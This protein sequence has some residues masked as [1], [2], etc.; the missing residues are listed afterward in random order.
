MIVKRKIEIFLNSYDMYSYCVVL[1]VCYI[2]YYIL[3]YII[4]L[5]IYYIM[6]KIK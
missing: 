5:Y 1:Y 2:L 3:F 4:I 6:I